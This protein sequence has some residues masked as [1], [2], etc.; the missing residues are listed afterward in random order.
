MVIERKVGRWR[1]PTFLSMAEEVLPRVGPV[2]DAWENMMNDTKDA[3]REDEPTFC[4]AMDNLVA[5]AG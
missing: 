1:R 3:L 5:A 2:L 4:D